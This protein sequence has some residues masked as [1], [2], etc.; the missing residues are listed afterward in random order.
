MPLASEVGRAY[1]ITMGSAG[2]VLMIVF[3]MGALVVCLVGVVAMA[4]GGD[5]N[6]KYSN[7]LMRARILFQFLALVAFAILMLAFGKS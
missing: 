1:I 5:F 6:K 4:R 7:K 2:T 3:M